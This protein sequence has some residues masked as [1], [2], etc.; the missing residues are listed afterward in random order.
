MTIDSKVCLEK[1]IDTK[2][3]YGRCYVDLI[4]YNS[5]DLFG[6]TKDI[7]IMHV[8]ILTFR[9]EKKA[10]THSHNQAMMMI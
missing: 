7:E 4:K 9:Q 2:I 3:F 8:F 5:I 6:K 10:E 1:K